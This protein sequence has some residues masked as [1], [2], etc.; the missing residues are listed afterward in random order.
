M[1]SSVPATIFTI[2]IKSHSTRVP[3]SR[4]HHMMSEEASSRT[5]SA[6]TSTQSTPTP[7]N[8]R[9]GR[10]LRKCATPIKSAEKVEQHEKVRVHQGPPTLLIPS[11]TNSSASDITPSSSG[12]TTPA[13]VEGE[14]GKVCT[15]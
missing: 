12:A 8:G 11:S 15:H 4:D 13:K 6:N 7:P 3:R 5:T 2:T 14:S 1:Y 9:R 10:R